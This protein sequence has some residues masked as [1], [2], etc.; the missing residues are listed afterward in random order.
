M[1][2]RVMG[3]LPDCCSDASP[4]TRGSRALV[5]TALVQTARELLAAALAD[6]DAGSYAALQVHPP[7][8]EHPALLL[9]HLRGAR[10]DHAALRP[11]AA[12]CGALMSD[13]G[14]REL[15]IRLEPGQ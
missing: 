5:A 11:H 14:Q 15:L 8:G 1:L 9:L 13:L 2:L 10:S 6:L 4:A 7:A 3:R 12:E